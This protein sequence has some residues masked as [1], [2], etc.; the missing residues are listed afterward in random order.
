MK[1]VVKAIIWRWYQT[2]PNVVTPNGSIES[3][4]HQ[5]TLKDQGFMLNQWTTWV[6]IC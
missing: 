6:S 1:K 5:T 3:P 4:S 2:C